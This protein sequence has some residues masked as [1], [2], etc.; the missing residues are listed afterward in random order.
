MQFFGG[1]PPKSDGAAAKPAASSASSSISEL[2]NDHS[3]VWDADLVKELEQ[4]GARV[5]RGAGDKQA[6]KKVRRRT[7]GCVRRVGTKISMASFTCFSYQRG[8]STPPTGRHALRGAN[9]AA[10]Q[11]DASRGGEGGHG[12]GDARSEAAGVRPGSRAQLCQRLPSGRRLRQRRARPGG[13]PLPT[14]SHSLWLA[15]EAQ[16][17]DQG[18]RG[19]L[20][21][22]M[23]SAERR[24]LQ[25]R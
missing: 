9:R 15:Q 14:H 19:S 2:P 11:G 7:T 10:A 24:D 4:A 16:V 1:P 13:R 18:V 3:F 5:P 23:A 22:G 6:N 20:H 17:P 21:A 25:P 12:D 8:Q